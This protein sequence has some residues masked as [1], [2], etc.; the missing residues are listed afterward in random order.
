MQLHGAPISL[1]A[2]GDERYSG[3]ANVSA[4]VAKLTHPDRSCCLTACSPCAQYCNGTFVSHMWGR[5]DEVR[6]LS[7]DDQPLLPETYLLPSS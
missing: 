6:A 5:K 2:P 1:W 7:R 4:H 3:S